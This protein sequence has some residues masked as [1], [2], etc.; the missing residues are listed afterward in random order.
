[1]AD[2][3]NMNQNAPAPEENI[4]AESISTNPGMEPGHIQ[5]MESGHPQS[6]GN[7]KHIAI[8]IIAVVIIASIIYYYSLSYKPTTPVVPPPTTILSHQKLDFIQ[9]APL[10]TNA[11]NGLYGMDAK[12]YAAFGYPPP[13]PYSENDVGITE[14]Y[15]MLYSL[16]NYSN[17]NQSQYLFSLKYINLDLPAV[18]YPAFITVEIDKYSNSSAAA[19]S[20]ETF[21]SN[22]TFSFEY[23]ITTGEVDFNASSTAAGNANVTQVTS[24]INKTSENGANICNKKV[25]FIYPN[26]AYANLSSTASIAIYSNYTIYSLGSGY[27]STINPA[28]TTSVTA[29]LLNIFLSDYNFS[30]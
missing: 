30:S 22:S 13:L 5:N 11:T 20:F 4:A 18:P 12:M 29:H 19:D 7:M 2:Q 26:G 23:N 16:K 8:A 14:A 21:C 15:H 10:L 6:S 27:Y 28:Y 25:N 9:I 17:L 3:D 1:M 24:I